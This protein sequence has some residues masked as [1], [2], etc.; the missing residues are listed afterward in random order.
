[1]KHKEG[2]SKHALLSFPVPLFDDR[3][4]GNV[5][6]CKICCTVAHT[7][8]ESPGRKRQRLDGCQNSPPS[9]VSGLSPTVALQNLPFNFFLSTLFFQVTHSP[10][11]VWLTSCTQL[12]STFLTHG[13]FCCWATS[14]RGYGWHCR[15][16]GLKVGLT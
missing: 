8:G 10:G 1:M 16:V 9:Q 3:M 4:L 14:L 13:G 7:L 5:N 2:R 15:K 12:M 6:Q 11:Y